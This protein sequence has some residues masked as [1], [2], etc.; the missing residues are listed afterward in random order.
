MSDYLSNSPADPTD[1]KPA[2]GTTDRR[3]LDT[4]T[5]VRAIE[6]ANAMEDAMNGNRVDTISSLA[7]WHGR[8][9]H[10]NGAV[11]LCAGCVRDENTRCLT[12]ADLANREDTIARF[13][14]RANGVWNAAAMVVEALDLS[15]DAATETALAG[16]MP[17]DGQ[18]DAIL[19]LIV[20][21][22]RRTMGWS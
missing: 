1:R 15:L 14:E 12:A 8:G 6:V 13:A 5:R 9:Q 20:R 17:G 21:E 16:A 3:P 22:V 2:R 11:T 18:Y 19:G 7:Y 10:G 4:D